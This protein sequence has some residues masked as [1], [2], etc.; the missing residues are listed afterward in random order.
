MSDFGHIPVLLDEVLEHLAPSSGSTAVDLT[1]GRGGHAQVMAEAVGPTGRLLGL[2]ADLDNVNF[3][4]N[5]LESQG[6]RCTVVHD[7]FARVADVMSAEEAVADVVLADL[8]VASIHLD[9]ADRGFSMAADG[10]LDMRLDRTRSHT[11]ADL[12]NSMPEADLAN[13]IQRLGEE[14]F[15]RRIASKIALSRLQG[16]I[17]TTG[18]LRDLVLEAYGA[19]AKASRRHPATRTFMALRIAVNDELA[20][21]DTLLARIESAAK[22][23][24]NGS[25]LAPGARVGIISF[26]SLEDRPVKRC[27]AGLVAQGLGRLP[28]RSGIVP[29]DEEIARNGRAR[30]ARLRILELVHP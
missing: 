9:Q 18:Q 6:L 10:P 22:G 11:A 16:P 5:R 29:S 4:R 15:G 13:L 2:D 7:N 21:L 20:A 25:W 3:S 24:G 14:P 1:L 17:T 8:G 23:A 27:F 12:V 19:R 26:H 30:S 28:H